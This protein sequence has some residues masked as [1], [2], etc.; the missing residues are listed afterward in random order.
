MTKQK[1]PN[2]KDAHKGGA[3]LDLGKNRVSLLFMQYFPNAVD[4][5]TSVS[6]FGAKKYSPGGWKE[7]P[8]G[9]QRYTD[10]LARHYL[11]DCK[12][13]IF[14]PETKLPHDF[15]LAWNALARIEFGMKEGKYGMK[16]SKP[17]AVVFFDALLDPFE[18]IE[19]DCLTSKHQ[20]L[21]KKA[22]DTLEKA[23]ARHE[24]KYLENLKERLIKKEVQVPNIDNKDDRG[25]VSINKMCDGIRERERQ[26]QFN[27]NAAAF[28]DINGV[29]WM[30]I[31][32][33][34]NFGYKVEKA[35]A[36]HEKMLKPHHAQDLES[37]KKDVLIIPTENPDLGKA[38][39]KSVSGFAESI[40]K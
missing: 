9:M 22:K 21:M 16:L 18:I 13:E 3:K 36:R 2:G 37:R 1:D 20:K 31:K 40:K 15:Q 7:V 4:A 32:K 38:V 8:E 17:D 35:V 28:V 12:G 19:D 33:K 23:A 6:E 27:P 26:M 5:V 39:A 10:A 14:D 25:Y 24:G 30:P 34:N 11:A 29:T